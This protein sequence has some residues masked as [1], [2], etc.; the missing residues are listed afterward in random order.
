MNGGGYG[1]GSLKLDGTAKAGVVFAIAQ[2]A[3]AESL[4]IYFVGVGE[5][6]DDLR[7]FCSRPLCASAVGYRLRK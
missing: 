5:A 1:L 2:K 4:P 6:E 3:L 7:P